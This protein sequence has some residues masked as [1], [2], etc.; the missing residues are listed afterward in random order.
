MKSYKNEKENTYRIIVYLHYWQVSMIYGVSN[1]NRTYTI[2][3]LTVMDPII[4]CSE[5]ID[6]LIRKGAFSVSK[7]MQHCSRPTFS[8]GLTVDIFKNV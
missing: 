4:M 1:V 6:W 8:N 5:K 2:I 3:L 7:V